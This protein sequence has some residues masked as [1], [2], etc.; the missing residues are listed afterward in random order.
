MKIEKKRNH[1]LFDFISPEITLFYRG[2]EKHSSFFSKDGRS[3][4]F[5]F[6]IPVMLST[7]S[8]AAVA[9]N[10]ASAKAGA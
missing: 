8:R 3:F 2:K 1:F 5:T 6:H 9:I 4:L 7:P 10:T